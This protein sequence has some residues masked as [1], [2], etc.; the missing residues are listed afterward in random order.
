MKRLTFILVCVVCILGALLWVCNGKLKQSHQNILRL[1]QNQQTL[2]QNIITYKTRDN[3][4]TYNTKRLSYTIDELRECNTDLLERVK[5]MNIRNRALQS[6]L[7]ISQTAKYT[8]C[9][10]TVFI[11]DTVKQQP[12]TAFQ[13]S[14]AWLEFC[15]NQ[16]QATITT[17][18]SIVVVNHCKMQRFLFW[19]RKRYTG[20]TNILNYN[21]HVRVT[22]ITSIEVEE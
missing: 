1:Q 17:R 18:D 16:G 12:Q 11:Y 7:Q 9:V 14:D 13:Y 6:A 21:P 20:Q 15:L 8:F 4:A 10:D 19:K 5:L 22:D 2:Q 3:L